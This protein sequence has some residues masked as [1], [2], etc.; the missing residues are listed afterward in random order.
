MNLFAVDYE[1]PALNYLVTMLK[2]TYPHADIFPFEK[3]SD[4]L[5]SA[6]KIKCDVAFL[7]ICL[8]SQNGI[9]L[10]KNLKDINGETNIIFTTGYTEYTYDAFRVYASDYLI[11]PIK[12]ENIK[13]AMNNLRT[14]IKPKDE[15]KLRIQCFGNFEVF[16][17]DEIVN[18]KRSKSKELLAYLVN[19]KGAACSMDEIISVLW[20]DVPFSEKTRSNLRNVI[21]DLKKQ[22]E[23]VGAKS[24]LVKARNSLAINCEK[25]I[26]DYFDFI[27]HIP[28][29]VNSYCGE[30]MSQYSWAEI[31]LA[32]I[33]YSR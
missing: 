10:A 24:V 16:N 30:Y 8:D 15:N 33:E 27:H 5:T 22:L 17:G 18:F 2:Q 29:A 14:P 3:V 13:R 11:K 26:C 7:D 12:S 25:I 21:S 9:E 4:A 31:T 6:K 20:E 19:R 32:E 1:R 23:S 28:Y